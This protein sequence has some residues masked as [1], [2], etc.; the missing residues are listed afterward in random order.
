MMQT[1]P[2]EAQLKEYIRDV[3]DFPK[4][5]I[6]FKDI[7]PLLKSPEALKLI[8][9]A[10][11]EVCEKDMPDYIAG[12]E[13]RGFILGMPLALELNVGFVPV[14][15][16]GKLPAATYRQEYTLE[17]GTDVLEIHKDAIEPGKKVWVIDDLL[18]TGGTAEATLK[19][20]A[21]SGADVLGMLFAIE[22]NF[23]NGR[24]KLAPCK[25]ISLMKY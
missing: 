22:L 10:M 12:I 5:G 18:A 16:A 13:S 15:K 21:Q 19:L 6:V 9:K 7:T 4:S 14:R 11:V 3:A 2:Q 20:L 17:Y 8:L 1:T 24:E 23:L 25:T